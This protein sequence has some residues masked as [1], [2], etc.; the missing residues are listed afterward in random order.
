VLFNIAETGGS[1]GVILIVAVLAIVA[2]A[3]VG[4]AYYKFV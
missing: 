3:G 2:L 4:F 1:T